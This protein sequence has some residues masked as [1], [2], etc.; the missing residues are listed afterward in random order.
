M[1]TMYLKMLVFSALILFGFH[2]QAQESGKAEYNPCRTLTIN[3]KSIPAQLERVLGQ[4]DDCTVENLEEGEF[5]VN[6][7]VLVRWSGVN[8]SVTYKMPETTICE[9]LVTQNNLLTSEWF[10]EN[11]KNLISDFFNMNWDLDEF[12]GPTSEYYTSPEAG[13]NAQFWVE[14]DKDGNVTWMRFSYAL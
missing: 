11:K 5:G 3:N 8:L 9:V 4:W 13:T 12:P 14:R 7:L 10:E 6:A 1:K 2:A